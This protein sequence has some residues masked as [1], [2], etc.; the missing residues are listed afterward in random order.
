MGDIYKSKELRTTKRLPEILNIW[1]KCSLFLH[2]GEKIRQPIKHW[3]KS[4]NI[5]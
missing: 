4:K 3:L 2:Y 1:Y 5:S